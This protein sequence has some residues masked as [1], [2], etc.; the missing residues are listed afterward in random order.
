[1]GLENW[2]VRRCAGWGVRRGWIL[3]H[4]SPGSCLELGRSCFPALS[5]VVE[6]SGW[7]NIS[8]A[9]F[10]RAACFSHT[11]L[12]IFSVTFLLW[13]LNGHEGDVCV[14]GEGCPLMASGLEL[15]LPCVPCLV[16]AAGMIESCVEAPTLTDSES[17]T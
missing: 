9:S 11:G 17:L 3:I 10:S 1:M 6:G 14:V 16:S 5:F 8:L 12:V 13:P 4:G 15:L 7:L 2:E